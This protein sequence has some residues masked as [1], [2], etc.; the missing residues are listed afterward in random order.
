MIP[1]TSQNIHPTH[2]VVQVSLPEI[3]YM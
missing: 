3:V 1:I 2:Q